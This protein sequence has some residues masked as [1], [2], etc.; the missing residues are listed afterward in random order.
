MR[1]SPIR[2]ILCAAA[3]AVLLLA[4]PE[5]ARA[6]VDEAKRLIVM[7]E[8]EIGGRKTI[9]AGIIVGT[10]ADR[11][12]IAT[13]NHVVRQ[14]KRSLEQVRVRL[15]FLPG[16]EFEAEVLSDFDRSLDLGVLSV[17]GIEALAIPLAEIP[18]TL[19]GESADLDRGDEVFAI[20]YP[21]GKR[22]RANVVPDPISENRGDELAFESQLVAK[23]HSGGGLFNDHWELVGMI[24]ADQ[25]PDGVATSIEAIL[26]TLTDWGYPVNLS[27]GQRTGARL[28]DSNKDCEVCPHMAKISQG[29]YMRGSSSREHEAFSLDEKM[30]DRESPR[31]WVTID[32]DFAVSQTEVTRAQFAAF[33]E[34]TG[35]DMSGGCRVLLGSDWIEGPNLSWRDPGFLQTDSDPAIC[36]SWK[37]AKDYAKWLSQKTGKPYRLPSAAEWEYVARA[38]STSARYWGDD[39]AEGNECEY[40]NGADLTAASALDLPVN[41]SRVFLCEDDF[42]YTAPVAYFLPNDFEIYDMI[43]NAMEWVEDCFHSDY[44]GAP[45]DGSAWTSGSCTRRVIRGGGWVSPPDELRAARKGKNVPDARLS[46]NGFRVAKTL[47]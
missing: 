24:I 39:R 18:F 43:G 8:G 7:I 22:W 6:D 14:G 37:D 15:K 34:E 33:V 46:S 36:I 17:K 25:P 13:A 23:G 42:V 10:A 30:A 45:L 31:H 29:R 35:R 32:Y 41:P 40:A 3:A 1:R 16:Q 28:A 27:P 11:L 19:L 47:D 5:P 2:L 26:A 4:G 9:G 21:R 38:K 20:G 12:Y 44:D